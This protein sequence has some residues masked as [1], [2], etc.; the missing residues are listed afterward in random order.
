MGFNPHRKHKTTPL[1]YAVVAAAL[2]I[3]IALVTWALVG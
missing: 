2:L 1:D 3:C